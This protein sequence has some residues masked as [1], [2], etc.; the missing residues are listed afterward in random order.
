MRALAVELHLLHGQMAP[1]EQR[2]C[3]IPI[4]ATGRRIILSTNVAETSLTIPGVKA[5]VDIGLERRVRFLPRTG[6]DHWDTLPISM[7]SAEQ[8]KGRA[9]R[10]GPGLCLRWWHQSDFH[11]PFAL[12]EIA[13]ADLAPLALHI[14]AWGTSAEELTWLTPPPPAPYSQA[15]GLLKDLGLINA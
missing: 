10:L 2:M 12:P 15:L 9:G 4:K 13:E 8:R 7:A 14:A 3:S 5:V 11:E 6:L 1:Q